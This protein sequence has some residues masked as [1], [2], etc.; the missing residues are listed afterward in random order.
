MNPSPPI[1][2]CLDSEGPFTDSVAIV[3]GASSREIAAFIAD[4]DVSVFSKLWKMLGVDRRNPRDGIW[5]EKLRQPYHV[6]REEAY[7][8]NCVQECST[9][10]AELC[11]PTLRPRK[12]QQPSQALHPDL[13]T[14][15]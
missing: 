9:S 2:D 8:L 3:G 14:T 11:C 6:D 13:T 12:A 15:H 4:A 7:H 10:S 1:E 5:A